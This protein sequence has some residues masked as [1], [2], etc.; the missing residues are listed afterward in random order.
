MDGGLNLTP[1]VNRPDLRLT[2]ALTHGKDA[3]HCFGRSVRPVFTTDADWARKFNEAINRHSTATK[4]ADFAGLAVS[5][6]VGVVGVVELEIAMLEA[7]YNNVSGAGSAKEL[8]RV[9]QAVRPTARD[10]AK[11]SF[12]SEAD[13]LNLIGQLLKSRTRR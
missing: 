1:T 12:F 3:V 13:L 10:L 5:P 8:E 4:L 11:E 9:R 2:T 7:K 6:R